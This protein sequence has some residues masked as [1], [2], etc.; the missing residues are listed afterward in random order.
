MQASPLSLGGGDQSEPPSGP[1]APPALHE[2]L[3]PAGCLRGQRT[4]PHEPR[5][6]R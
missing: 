4:A 2:E 5:P 1:D 3:H 6:P